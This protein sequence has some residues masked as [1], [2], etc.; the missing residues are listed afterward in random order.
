M[1][2]VRGSAGGAS[3]PHRRDS[4]RSDSAR[5]TSRKTTQP[6]SRPGGRDGHPGTPGGV[7]STK[8]QAA[9]GKS[10][11]KTIAA[12]RPAPPDGRR[13]T[14]RAAML[15]AVI[16]VLMLS[17][18]YPTKQYLE[19]RNQI[20]QNQQDKAAQQQRILQLREEKQRWAGDDHVREQARKR[21]QYVERGELTYVVTDDGRPDQP[22]ST[23]AE[24]GAQ[25]QRAWYGEIWRRLQVSGRSSS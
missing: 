1:T 24:A 23:D 14:R 13:F 3:S 11:A 10:P 8:P 21:L 9:S 6:P 2:S 7:K 4:R 17:L 16:A 18:A 5:P 20:A 25:S 22:D 12:R 19:Q 15:A